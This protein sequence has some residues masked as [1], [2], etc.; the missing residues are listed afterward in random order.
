MFSIGQTVKVLPPFDV[1][2]TGN[3][4]ITDIVNSSDGT[5]TYILGDA[6]GF[7]AVYLELV[8]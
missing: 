4:I 3:F 7:D 1:S 2:F 5:A 8:A 6:G